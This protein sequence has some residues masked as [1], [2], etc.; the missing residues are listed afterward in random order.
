MSFNIFLI[1][2]FAYMEMSKDSPAKHYQNNI[3]RL[4][5]KKKKKKENSWKISKS[6][7]RR[8]GKKQNGFKGYK[9][10]PEEEKQKLVGWV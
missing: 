5:K 1:Y 2:L 9:N 10:L 3:E 7:Y 4:E 8:K 6:F